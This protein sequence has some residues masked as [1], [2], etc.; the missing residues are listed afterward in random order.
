[1]S[2]IQLSKLVKVPLRNVWKHEALDFTQWLAL[3]ENIQALSEV[4]E[5]ELNDPKPEVGVGK[6]WVDIVAKDENDR[7][8][9]IENQ[10]E[11]TNHDHLGKI[12]TYPAGLGAD[13]VIWIVQHAR[14]SMSRPS[15]G[16]TRTPPRRRTSS[17][18]RSRLGRSATPSQRR[19]ST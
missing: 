8:V 10:L 7:T 12:I 6:F 15:S 17:S 9:V 4:I 18:C 19:A 13:V 11:S 2:E 16:S 14:K 1:V 3:P 5:I